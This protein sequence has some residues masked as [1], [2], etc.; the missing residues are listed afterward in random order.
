MLISF[1]FLIRSTYENCNHG[2]CNEHHCRTLKFVYEHEKDQ[3]AE[4]M[5]TLLYEIKDVVDEK[6]EQEK[7]HL[8]SNTINSFEKKYEEIIKE[9]YEF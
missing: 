2:L 6:K 3:W 9:A 8:K 7:D 1:Y 5:E 4:K